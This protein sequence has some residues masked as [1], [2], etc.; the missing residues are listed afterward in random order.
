[1]QG[2]QRN[3]CAKPACICVLFFR[4]VKLFSEIKNMASKRAFLYTFLTMIVVAL[5]L[6]G[7]GR[8]EPEPTPTP[9]KTPAAAPQQAAPAVTPTPVPPTPTPA[10]PTPAPQTNPPTA[11][12][13][14]ANV[15]PYTGLPVDDPARLTQRPI[16]VCINNDA[17]GRSAHY[18]LSAADLV[19]EY[20][21]DGFTVTRISAL[22]QSHDAERIGPVRSARMPNIWMTYMYDGVLA[23]SGGSDEIRYLLKNEVGFPY[24]D[25]DID[26]P[27][28]NVYFFS[29]GSDYR[30]RLQVSTEGVRRWLAA[31]GQVKE[32]QRPGFAFSPEPAPFDAGTAATIQIPYPGGNSV[33]WR[34]DP[35][36]NIYLRFQGGVPHMDNATGAQ[37]TA[38][39]VIVMFANH[40]LTDIVE[41]SLGTK[42]VDIELYGFGDFRIFRD[43]R[44]YEGTW[45]ANDQ[46]PPRWLG[47]GEQI[48]PLKP[49]QSWIQV[50]RN[51]DQ[52]TYQ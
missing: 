12:P 8:S 50:V 1:M 33:E 15:A 39:N 44:V 43:G 25:A 26:D 3:L 4:V 18:G 5:A 27:S 38:D 21:V 17:V 35:E 11:T 9:T 41:D 20:I 14:P 45:R 47:P 7:C 28:N 48:V 6:A 51:T 40:A 29:I 34:Y 37:I 2:A 19:Y 16:F 10:P 24:L 52:I 36:R 30:T 23:C 32:W 13:Q 49:G 22:Y 46:S 42:G 31:T